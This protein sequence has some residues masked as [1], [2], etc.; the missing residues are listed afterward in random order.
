[1]TSMTSYSKITEEMAA[2]FHTAFVDGT[3]ASNIA[4]RPQ[5]I[6]NDYREGKKVLSSIEDELLVCD[7]FQISVAFITLGG[8]APLLLTLKELE[9]RHIPGE[10]LTSNYLIFCE[11]KA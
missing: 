11:P 6:S 9:K 3:A 1:M 8:I 7:R 10:I 2:G 4:Y 5:F